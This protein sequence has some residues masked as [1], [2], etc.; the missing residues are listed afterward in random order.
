[1]MRKKEGQKVGFPISNHCLKRLEIKDWR[2]LKGFISNHFEKW[3]E[4]T[5]EHAVE[6]LK[7]LGS[8]ISGHFPP[9]GGFI[10]GKPPKGLFPFFLSHQKNLPFRIEKAESRWLMIFEILDKLTEADAVLL[11][12][13]LNRLDLGKSFTTKASSGGGH[14]KPYTYFLHY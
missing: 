9:K 11:L 1:M 8:P 12:E 13:Q 7:I 6:L 5:V 2:G 4:M 14:T 10:S 3:L